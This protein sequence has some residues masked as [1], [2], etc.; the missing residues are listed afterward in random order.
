MT[1]NNP[2]SRYFRQPTIYMRLPSRGRHYP[3]GTIDLPSNSELP[4]YPMTVRDEII[5]KTPDALF[6]GSAVVNLIQSCVPNIKD[7][8]AIPSVDID[9]ILIAIKVATYGKD[10]DI[11][12]SC[13]HCRESSDYVIDLNRVLAEIGTTDYN[14]P[15]RIGQFELMFRPLSY[16]EI[17]ETSKEQFN[18]QK[19][20]N[21][22]PESGLSD[23]ERVQEINKLIVKITDGT[24]SALSKS[25]S[26]IRTDDVIVTDEQQINEFLNNC[27]NAMFTAIRDAAVAKRQAGAMKPL[28]LTCN[29]CE[30]QYEQTLTLDLSNF[31]VPSS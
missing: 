20:L 22:L 17:N 9:S 6:N 23:Q 14:S 19:I 8:W 7:A 2:L 25:I 18:E 10:L 13:T 3:A 12:G 30:K 29:H 24:I 11:T 16:H 31:F 21:I 5:N 26:S 4:V 15:Q 28:K 1:E 27:P